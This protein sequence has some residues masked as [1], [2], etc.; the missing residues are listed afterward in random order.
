MDNHIKMLGKIKSKD[1]FLEFMNLYA[2]NTKETSVAEYLDSIISWTEDMDGYYTNKNQNAPKNIDWDFIATLL[3]A[4][5]IY[6]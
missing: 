5:S 6:E 2:Q 4:G 3:Y 1:E